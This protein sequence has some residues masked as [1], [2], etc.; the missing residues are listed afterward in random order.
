MLIKALS[1]IME[2]LSQEGFLLYGEQL[3]IVYK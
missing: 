3:L 2:V 1:G